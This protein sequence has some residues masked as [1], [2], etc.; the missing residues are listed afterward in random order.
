[1]HTSEAEFGVAD[2][3]TSP[4]CLLPQLLIKCKQQVVMMPMFISCGPMSNILLKKKK[5]QKGCWLVLPSQ[6]HGVRWKPELKVFKLKTENKLTE[7]PRAIVPKDA[8]KESPLL[9]SFYFSYFTL[10]DSGNLPCTVA[11]QKSPERMSR[12]VA[13]WCVCVSARVRVLFLHL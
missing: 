1:M 4:N 12:R 3:G 10:G 8:N 13:G 11:G 6:C 9:F 5:K 2:L 7:Y